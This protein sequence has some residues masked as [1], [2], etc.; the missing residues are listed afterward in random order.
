MSEIPQAAIDAAVEALIKRYE[1]PYSTPRDFL[2]RD[3]RACL[4]A[5]EPHLAA[6]RTVYVLAIGHTLDAD[7]A[8]RIQ[9]AVTTAL[10]EPRP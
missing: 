7:D 6:E 10:R 2:E 9:H 4:E 8:A 1:F 5:A 3:V